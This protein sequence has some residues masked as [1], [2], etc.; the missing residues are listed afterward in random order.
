MKADACS[1]DTSQC[2]LYQWELAA[3]LT[4]G[5]GTGIVS[6]SLRQG[7]GK[8]T[9]ISLS[10]PV[11]QANYTGSCCSQIVEFVAVDKVGNVGKCFH[12]IV[13]SAGLSASSIAATM[14]SF[15]IH[16]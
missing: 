11:V 7:K 3:N 1:Q 9:Y 2:G 4:D 12:S 15:H 8:I 13:S 16:F 6:V 5:N 10:D 14:A